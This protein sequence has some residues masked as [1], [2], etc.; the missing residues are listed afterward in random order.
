MTSE[1]FNLMVEAVTAEQL[2]DAA[3]NHAWELAAVEAEI[4]AAIV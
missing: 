2:S 1:E 4:E 3:T